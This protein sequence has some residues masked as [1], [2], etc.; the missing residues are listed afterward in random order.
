MQT[1]T[2]VV[3]ALIDTLLPSQWLGTATATPT[4]TAIG[5]TKATPATT[6]IVQPPS[7]I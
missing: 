6:V 3:N 5:T 4:A 2:V 7:E 1:K